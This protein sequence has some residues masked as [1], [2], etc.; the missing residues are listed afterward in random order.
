MVVDASQPITVKVLVGSER[1]VNV[2]PLLPLTDLVNLSVPEAMR[3]FCRTLA[4][5]VLGTWR[6]A[7][8][9]GHPLCLWMG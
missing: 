6:P 8:P 9:P 3:T 5:P 7:A 1:E 2:N 4:K